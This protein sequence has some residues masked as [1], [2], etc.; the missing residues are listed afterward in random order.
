M[1]STPTTEPD[2]FTSTPP[3]LASAVDALLEGGLADYIEAVTRALA[4]MDGAVYIEA[5]DGRAAY[6]PVNLR[7][8]DDG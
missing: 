6:T 5:R 7:R 8:P 1:T 4:D 3:H 2:P